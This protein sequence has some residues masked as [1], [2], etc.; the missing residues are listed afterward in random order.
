MG[1]RLIHENVQSLAM[2]SRIFSYEFLMRNLDRM[3]VAFYTGKK[4]FIC[5]MYKHVPNANLMIGF[6][7][8]EHD[9]VFIGYYDDDG[10][11]AVEGTENYTFVPF[12]G[13]DNVKAIISQTAL[14]LFNVFLDL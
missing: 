12:N 13:D 7:N 14:R 2:F 6:H 11:P 1:Y 3:E 9:G 5:V 8:D 4:N 10:R